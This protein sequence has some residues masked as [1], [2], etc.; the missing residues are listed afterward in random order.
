MADDS[1]QA[2]GIS[3]RRSP[4]S[5]SPAVAAFGEADKARLLAD[6]GIVRNRLKIEAAVANA[7]AALPVIDG[8]GSLAAFFWA[9]SAGGARGAAH[10][11]R[12]RRREPR[13]GGAGQG[14]QA[15]RLPFRRPDDRL[16]AHAGGRDRQRP[17]RRLLRLGRGRRR[18]GSGG[19]P[20]RLAAAARAHASA[21]SRDQRVTRC[22]IRLGSGSTPSEGDL[23][24]A[25]Q[26]GQWWCSSSA[27]VCSCRSPFTS[28][29]P[30]GRGGMHDPRLHRPEHL[31]A[32]PRHPARG[33]PVLRQVARHLLP[34]RSSTCRRCATGRTR[35]VQD[36]LVPVLLPPRRGG[37]LRAHAGARHPLHLPQHVRVLLRLRRGGAHA[38]ELD[39][40]G[41]V[42]GDPLRRRSSGSSSSCRRSGG[43]TSPSWT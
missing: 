24:W 28:A 7:R 10:A 41:Q 13:V 34:G 26:S 36:E 39:A 12:L 21:G 14:A 15:A 40:H 38:L 3:G 29:P 6:A 43:S 35:R 2:G 19:I 4:A 8:Q 25:L 42:D 31:P 22:R 11:G 33:L 1:A 9:L 32:V 17:R 16:R 23:A 5:T 27:P 20:L 37:H 30:G 18:T